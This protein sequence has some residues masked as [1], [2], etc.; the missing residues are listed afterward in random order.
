VINGGLSTKPSAGNV[1]C[2]SDSSLVLK[3]TILHVTSPAS[4]SS[5]YSVKFKDTHYSAARL[6]LPFDENNGTKRVVGFHY[7]ETTSG[8]VGDVGADGHEGHERLILP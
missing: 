1:T 2:S 5:R 8:L 4:T 3:S 7:R 6:L